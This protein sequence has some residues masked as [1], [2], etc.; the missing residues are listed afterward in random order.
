MGMF[1]ERMGRLVAGKRTKWITLLVWILLAA[2]LS[3]VWPGVKSMEQNNA[4]NLSNDK[5]SVQASLLAEQEFPNDSG[6][7]ALLVWNREGGLNDDD[8]GNI[9]KLTAYF[10]ENPVEGQEL[11]P[12]FDRIPLP[13]LKAEASE[14]GTAFVLPF[15]FEKA[16][17][18]E[19]MESGIEE[20][21]KQAEVLFGYDPFAVKQG[22]ENEISARVSGPAGISIDAVGLFSQ[23]D[24]S[25]MIATVL[26]V[27]I[28]LLLIYRS[29]ILAIIPIIAVG[30]A[31]G[32]SSPILGKMAE[33]GWITFDSQAISIMTVLLFGAGTDY[34]LFLISHFRQYLT[35]ES[36][37]AKALLKSLKDSSGA[38][39]MSGFTVVIALLVLLVA[40]YGA[41]HRFA[42]PFSLSI[43]IMAFASLTLVP[44]LLA[45]L[46][47]A[48]FYPFVPRTPEMQEERARKKGKELK[49][50]NKKPIGGWIGRV[51]TK[52]PWAVVSITV[53]LLGALALNATRIEYTV[54]L[55][56]SFPE[57]TPSREGF[58]VIGEKFTPGE[59]A[60]VK[61]MVDT[62]GK[63]VALQDSFK[64]LPYISKVSDPAQGAAN[65]N[66]QAIDLEFNINPYTNE[67]MNHIPDIRA[68]AEKSLQDA[69][70]SSPENKVWI[71]GQTATQYDTEMTDSRDTKVIIPIV[72]GLIGL[73]LLV[74]LRSI[75]AMI[76]LILTVVLSYFSALGLGWI[77]IHDFMGAAAIQGLIPVYAFVFLVAL[78]EDYNIFLISSIWKKR[79]EMPLKQAIQEGVTETGGV[80][81]SAGLILAGTF[82]VL[83]TLP[84]QVLVQFGIITAIGVLLDTFVVRPFLVPAITM[85]LGKWAFWPGRHKEKASGKKTHDRVETLSK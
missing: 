14:D 58:A 15:F 44:A 60:P 3:I 80:I 74:Y 65:T 17:D 6:I 4:P 79:K 70:V 71:S 1:F 2:V 67:A 54:D 30:F 82:A 37:K 75:V 9:Q 7:P 47:R 22:D 52:R 51:V 18:S 72:I 23:A 78:G 21:R 42:V 56:S 53:V 57:D 48:S 41:L 29:P 20:I 49:A 40:E 84:I 85:L 73:L 32:V 63:E 76:Y 25:L 83:A 39:A 68:E 55:L 64:D 38:I 45:I 33:L 77:V 66:I 34:C 5:P 81:T 36:S 16:S 59:L 62:E 43:L 8:F 10:T 26:I 19:I 35:E 11:V 69:G 61:L 13:A 28:L 27:L 46:G 31:Y 12:P 50:T 24:V